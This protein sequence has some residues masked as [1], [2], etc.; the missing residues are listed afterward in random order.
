[1]KHFIIIKKESQ[2]VRNK[3]FQIVG[4]VPLWRNLIRELD[5]QDVYI[6]TNSE[7]IIKSCKKIKYITCYKR[8][9]KHIELESNKDFALSP[10]LLMI[11]RFLDTYVEDENEVIVTPHV[12]SPFIKLE[13][14]KKAA[15]KLNQ[16]FNSVQA[17]TVHKEFAYYKNKPINFNSSVIQKTQDLEPILLGNGA[18]FIF[19]KKTF[20]EKNNRT[21][22]NPF[23][24]PLSFEEGIEI[25][26]HE[27]L[28]LARR[29]AN[30]R[31]Y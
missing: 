8:L 26:T 1:M 19:T 10:A 23:F 24:Y 4:G 18:F 21:G 31:N 22:S 29:W 9:N 20:K 15:Q 11:E 12:T 27:D 16:G 5:G 17:C 2:R 6:D 30:G 28:E 14:I 13:T 25:D 7:D 3:N